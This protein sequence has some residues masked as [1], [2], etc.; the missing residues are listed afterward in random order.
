MMLDFFARFFSFPDWRSAVNR[1]T[2]AADLIAGVT[3]AVI[4]LP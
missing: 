3:G 1:Q 4:V 2:L